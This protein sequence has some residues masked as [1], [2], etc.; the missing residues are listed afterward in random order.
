MIEVKCEYCDEMLLYD[1][2]EGQYYNS[3]KQPIELYEGLLGCLKD[4]GIVCCSEDCFFDSLDISKNEYYRQVRRNLSYQRE[5][6][7]GWEDDYFDY[8]REKGEM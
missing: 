6:D 8:C 1:E 4:D 5:K 2:Y 3:T 7:Y